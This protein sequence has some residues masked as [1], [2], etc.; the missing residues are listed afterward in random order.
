MQM[1][2]T[3]KKHSFDRVSIHFRLQVFLE[4]NNTR[5]KTQNQ[6][7]QNPIQIYTTQK[8]LPAN[9]CMNTIFHKKKNTQSYEK[10]QVDANIFHIH[11]KK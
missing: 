6:Q 4:K 2:L 10:K 8:R 7:R 11:S 1:H 3:E 9:V 5:Y